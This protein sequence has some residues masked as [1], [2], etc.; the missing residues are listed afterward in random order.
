MF[1]LRLM[2]GVCLLLLLLPSLRSEG[3]VL[4]IAPLAI[5]GIVMAAGSVYTG[6]SMY[7]T[8][9]RQ[10][11]NAQQMAEY[12]RRV[13]QTRAEQERMNRLR[14]ESRERRQTRRRRALMEAAYAR[15][16]VLL[17]GTPAYMLGE[18]AAVDEL[19]ISQKTQESEQKQQGLITHGELSVWQGKQQAALY[20]AQGK[21]A[22]VK[23]VTGAAGS[24]ASANADSDGSMFSW[25]TAEEE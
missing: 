2:Q 24:L 1:D 12:N 22:L 10:A 20:E 4:A 13:A 18:Q 23:G 25:M 6:A 9:R 7:M 19:T 14:N 5:A 21:A 8:S 17:E 15:S 3:Y 11:K 16:G